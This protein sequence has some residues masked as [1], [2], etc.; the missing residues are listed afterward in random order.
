MSVLGYMN[1][2]YRQRAGRCDR[3]VVSAS[4]DEVWLWK[5]Q[6]NMAGIGGK[7]V[8]SDTC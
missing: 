1:L 2:I 4:K 5:S 8:K 7:R 6:Y 3:A